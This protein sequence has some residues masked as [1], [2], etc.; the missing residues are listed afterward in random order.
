MSLFGGMMNFEAKDLY[1]R[2]PLVSSML[3]FIPLNWASISDT[4]IITTPIVFLLSRR[5]YIH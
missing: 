2:M 3:F 4:I 5:Y 1:I